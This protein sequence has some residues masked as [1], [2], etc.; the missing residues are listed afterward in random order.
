M[1]SPFT[2][3]W[4][5]LVPDEWVTLGGAPWKDLDIAERNRESEINPAL[6]RILPRWWRDHHA[7]G[8]KLDKRVLCGQVH[9]TSLKKKQQIKLDKSRYRYRLKKKIKG[10]IIRDW[11]HLVPEEWVSLDGTAWG[12]MTESQRDKEASLNPA[13]R[14]ILPQWWRDTYALVLLKMRYNRKIGRRYAPLGTCML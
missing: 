2:R 6:R 5:H 10:R 11:H 8:L 12:D 3:A 13:L 14:R 9:C 4:H 1:E 7:W